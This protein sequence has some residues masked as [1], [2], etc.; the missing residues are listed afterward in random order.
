M[1][2]RCQALE[3]LDATVSAGARAH[4][5]AEMLGCGSTTLQ[6]WR[7]QFAADP[8]FAALL[9]GQILLILADRGLSVSS[10]Q[11]F[12]RVLNDNSRS[13]AGGGLSLLSNRGRCQGWRPEV[14][15]RFGVGISLTCPP[16]CGASGFTS[17]WGLLINV[18]PLP[19]Q[20]I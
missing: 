7:R 1:A 20:L 18:R 4:K 16:A 5:V 17:I 10:E 13:T 11:S 6:R 3:I 2:D 19:L 12:Y 14:P 15:I 9:P 8:D